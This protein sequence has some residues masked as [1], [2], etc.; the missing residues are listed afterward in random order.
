[1]R[2]QKGGLGLKK[3]VMSLAARMSNSTSRSGKLMPPSERGRV[4]VVSVGGCELELCHMSCISRDL[5]CFLNG[6]VGGAIEAW[7]QILDKTRDLAT[8]TLP[9]KERDRVARDLVSGVILVMRDCQRDVILVVVRG[10]MMPSVLMG[11]R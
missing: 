6:R 5:I 7:Y 3:V 2:A 1:M 9:Q 4:A 10:R 11:P 8:R